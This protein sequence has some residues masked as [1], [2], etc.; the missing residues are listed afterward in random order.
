MIPPTDQVFEFGSFRLDAVER[1]LSLDGKPI[2]ISVK[3]FDT[4]VFMIRKNG[5]LIEK[6]ELIAEIWPDSFVEEG[7]LKVVIWALRKALETQIDGPKYIQTV[8]KHGYR[9]VGDV[10]QVPKSETEQPRLGAALAS[11]V[12]SG[13]GDRRLGWTVKFG[14][15]ALALLGAVGILIRFERP[16][17]PRAEATKTSSLAV[18]PFEPL[19]LSPDKKYLGLGMADAVIT[20]LGSA[21]QIVV[22]P[23]SSVAKYVLSPEDPSAIGRNLR[24]D[25]V[26]EGKIEELS[27]Q[28]RVSIQLVR[29]RDGFLLWADTFVRPPDQIFALE[30]DVAERV[31]GSA[32]RQRPE[33]A[34]T[35]LTRSETKDSKAYPLY[36]NGLYLLNKRSPDSVRQ[37]ID[38]FQQAIALDPGYAPSYADLAVAYVTLGSYGD[39]PVQLYPHAEVAA[40]KAIDLDN[41]LAAAH[42]A[43]AQ[44][45]FHY[46]WKWVEAE[47]QFQ[48]AIQLAPNDAMT[49]SWYGLYLAAMGRNKEAVEQGVRAQQLD[50]VSPSVNASVGRVFY[51]S[52]EYDRAIDRFKEVLT[53]EPKFSNGH[54]RLGLTYLAQGDQSNALREFQSAQKLAEASPYLD[55]LLGYVQ[56]K[57]GNTVEAHRA[58]EDL[59][60]RSQTQYVPA[61]GIALIYI[62]LNDHQRALDWLEKAYQERSPDMAYAKI[63]PFLDPVRSDRRFLELIQKMGM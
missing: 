38:Y 11:P 2:S 62:G 29:A 58:V 51:W 12:G 52:R 47:K 60:R 54:T 17:S 43:L 59:I 3:A 16:L 50:P 9:F 55:G 22:R 56:A 25:A 36:L 34:R 26:L 61:F 57:A 48:S 32:L 14:I 46:D 18:L 30:E 49:H 4:L 39:P 6:S 53:L 1:I 44:E 10:R 27:D 20:R 5:R 21:G 8:A 23:T 63:D 42:A 45:S 19:N 35:S 33:P 15:L 40:A 41:S 7:N 13:D 24:V 31:T 28:V 37:S